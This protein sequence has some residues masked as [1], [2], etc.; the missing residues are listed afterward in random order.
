MRSRMAAAALS[1]IGQTGNPWL[2][3]LDWM[4]EESGHSKQH[5]V[6][7]NISVDEQSSCAQ[8]YSI[9]CV[10]WS[11]SIGERK[12]RVCLVLTAHMW[13]TLNYLL[14]SSV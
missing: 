9:G 3:L 5:S 13:A 12:G 7:T 1:K 6:Q 4:V 11:A 2:S 8:E 14:V 10:A